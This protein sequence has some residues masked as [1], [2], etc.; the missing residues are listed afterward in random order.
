MMYLI[1][2]RFYSVGK[3]HTYQFEPIYMTF[4]ANRIAKCIN[5]DIDEKQRK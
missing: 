3:C 2:S 5:M 4:L 1:R